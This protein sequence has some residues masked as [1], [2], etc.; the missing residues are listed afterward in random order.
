MKPSATAALGCGALFSLPFI[1]FGVGAMVAAFSKYG[2]GDRSGA[3]ALGLFGLVFSLV[4]FGLLAAIISGHRQARRRERIEEAH[5]ESPWLWREDWAAGQVRDSQRSAGAA[6]WGFALFWNLIALPAGFFGVRSAL[7]TGNPGGWM[8]LLFPLVGLGLVAA[9]MRASMRSRKF[10]ASRL[11]LV[12]IPA[13]IGHGLGGVIRTPADVRSADGFALALSCV[14]IVRTRSGKNRSTRETVLWQEEKRVAGQ[15]GAGGPR[16]GIVTNI[17]VAF[18][19][20]VDAET[21]DERN[22]NDRVVWRLR[23][24]A[25]VPGVDYESLFE[26]PVFRTAASET[27]ATADTERLLGAEPSVAAW[28]Q[29]AD[30]PIRDTTRNGATEVLFPAARNRGAALGVTACAAIWAVCV[31]AVFV[32]DAPLVFKLV[33]VLLE[34]L[35]VYAMLRLW[36]R[37]VRV[38]ADRHHLS[39]TAGFGVPG[40]PRTVPAGEVRNVEFRI[41][42]QSGERVWYDLYVVRADGR[43]LEAGGGIRDKREAEWIAARLLE[44]V[45]G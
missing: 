29:P 12:T 37:V 36:F 34:L 42:M 28:K 43:K 19:I 23:A 38:T 3:A 14:R 45:R 39:V 30:S 40:K 1:G 25:S 13:V 24:T 26:V 20:P 8:G 35:I 6:L 21:C 31:A 10:G 2:G 16:D 17:P 11:D 32:L 7:T 18:R 5:P 22:P 44:A 33:F 41:G 9:A 27:P 15:R 4:G